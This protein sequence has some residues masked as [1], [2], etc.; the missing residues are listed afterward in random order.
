MSDPWDSL[1]AGVTATLRDLRPGEFVVI[2]FVEVDGVPAWSP[3]PY[4]QCAPAEEGW[5]CEAVSADH[6]PP[7]QWPLDELALRRAG[8][9]APV[10]AEGNWYRQ[11]DGAAEA[12]RSMVEALRHSRDCQDPSRFRWQ[13]GTLPSGPGNGSPLSLDAGPLRLAA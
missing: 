4:A 13:V 5:Y 12:A 11:A 1:V 9:H 8:W 2:E 7:H 6:L 3:W 10:G